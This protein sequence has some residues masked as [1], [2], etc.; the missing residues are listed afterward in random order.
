MVTSE[1]V[2]RLTG[3]GLKRVRVLLKS[4]KLPVQQI[5]SPPP[6][7]TT[8]AAENAISPNALKSSSLV[9]LN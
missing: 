6:P 2:F 1:R 7:P 8:T 5:D 3:L 9:M 4:Q